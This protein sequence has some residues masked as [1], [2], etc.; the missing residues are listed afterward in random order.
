MWFISGIW[1]HCDAEHTPYF[2]EYGYVTMTDKDDTM[3]DDLYR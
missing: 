1:I 3:I 2:D